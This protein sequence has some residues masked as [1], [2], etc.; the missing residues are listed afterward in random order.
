MNLY[1]ILAVLGLFMGSLW[2]AYDYGRDSERLEQA[3]IIEK[4]RNKEA[5]L[6]AKL[7]EAKANREVITNERIRIVRET[8]DECINR[9]IP[10]PLLGS[11]LNDSITR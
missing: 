10:E 8:V 4:H 7:E 9:P 5:D 1:A 2:F 3:K 6:V 11:L